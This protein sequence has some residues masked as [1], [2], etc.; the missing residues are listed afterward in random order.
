MIITTHFEDPIGTVLQTRSFQQGQSL[1][2]VSHAIGLLG[3]GEPGLP[4]SV[5]IESPSQAFPPLYQAGR[6][7]IGGGAAFDFVLPFVDAKANVVVTVTFS[8]SD[9]ATIPISIGNAY[10]DPL[11]APP[12][13]LG[14]TLDN[15]L[16]FLAIGG[17]IIALIWAL[18]KSGVLSGK[19]K[20]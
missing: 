4:I 5:S 19:S 15:A 17:V 20:K 7:G 9:I 1:R 8:G 2:V 11:P 3:L 16:K 6:T 12:P 13:G 14:D 18:Q 10:P